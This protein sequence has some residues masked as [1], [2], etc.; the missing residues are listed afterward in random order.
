MKLLYIE[1]DA[2]IAHA[3]K[4]G[5]EAEGFKVEHCADGVDGLWRAK[6]FTYDLILLDVLLPG[7]NGY[8]ICTELRA[9][10]DWTPIVMLTAKSG[11]F[12]ESE[13]LDI[14]AD[15]YLT[16]PFSFAVLVSRIRANLR[17]SRTRSLSPVSAGSL[18]IDPAT[19]HVSFNGSAISL[20]AREFD[21]LEF[22]VRRCGDVLGKDQILAGVWDSAFDG[23]LNIVEVYIRRLRK[24]LDGP[25]DN[26]VIET[27][28]GVGYRIRPIVPR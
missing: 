7:R 11:E 9:A 25:M 14:G 6:E 19:R 24:K 8:K 23:D 27:I 17:R 13:G 10:G 3:I 20:T 5:L 26:S 16:K 1:D 4:R 12:D 15:D 28:R 18:L 2:K 21:V 22:L